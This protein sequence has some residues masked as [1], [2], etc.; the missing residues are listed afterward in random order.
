MKEHNGVRFY[1][2][3]LGVYD[4]IEYRESMQSGNMVLIVPPLGVEGQCRT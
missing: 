3:A 4:G 1:M 2:L